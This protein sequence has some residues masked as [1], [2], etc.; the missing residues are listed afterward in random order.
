MRSSL[1]PLVNCS[2]CGI[3]AVDD[4]QPDQVVSFEPAGGFMRNVPNSR[5]RDGLRMPRHSGSI[6]GGQ[7]IADMQMGNNGRS[8]L[9]HKTEAF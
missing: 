3:S 2:G 6:P 1:R 9:Y 4:A 8:I 7:Y 5:I